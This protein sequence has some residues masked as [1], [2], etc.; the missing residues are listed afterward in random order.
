MR[1]Y[2]K[3][4]SEEVARQERPSGCVGGAIVIPG[5]TEVPAQR[6]VTVPRS[7]QAVLGAECVM[8]TALARV[9]LSCCLTT[10]VTH[11]HVLH[12]RTPTHVESLQC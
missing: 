10:V 11:S 7:S 4:C 9:H 3:N 5:L 1:A 6:L 2:L 8:V 12:T